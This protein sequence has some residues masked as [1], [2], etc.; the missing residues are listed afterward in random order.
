MAH[1]LEHVPSARRDAE[2]S[3]ITKIDSFLGSSAKN[4]H[5]VIDQGRGMSFSGNWYITYT[6][7]LTPGIGLGVVCPDIIEPGNAIC[8]AESNL[9]LA[10]FTCTR[11]D[12]TGTYR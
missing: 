3:K 5:S 9:I 10:G 8:T 7:K 11:L 6:V 12:Q 4:V 2:C 1:V